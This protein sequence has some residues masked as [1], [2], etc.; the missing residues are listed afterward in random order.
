MINVEQVLQF[1]ELYAP[2]TLAE[3][4][5][6]VGL[7]VGDLQAQVSRVL[8]ALDVTE[9]VVQEA[10]AGKFDL[11]IAHHPLIFT[12]I[13]AV[14]TQTT[15]GRAII[16]AVRNNVAVICM[17]TNL[18]CAQG[19]V[20]DALAQA[21]GLSAVVPMGAGEQGMLGRVGKLPAQMSPAIFADYVLEALDAG[22]VRYCNGGT[23]IRT[24]AV[25]GGAC[26]KLMDFALEK[27]AQA[28]VVGECTYDLM[29]K[30]EALG[31]TLVDAG[32]FATENPIVP[33]LVEKIKQA[34]PQLE[35]QMSAVHGDC[36]RYVK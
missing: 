26:G 30:A 8:C 11:I 35:V 13:A 7:L 36:I 17:H 32:H 25:G 2:K 5:D 19:G 18:D 27:G 28:F 1:M 24:V 33:K 23:P 34:M 9:A 21:L 14:T 12:S 22:G 3:G 6:N 29:Q 20:N 31:L 4:W 10:V 16:N 15:T